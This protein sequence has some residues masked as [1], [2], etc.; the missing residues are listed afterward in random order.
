MDSS[1]KDNGE[2][3]TRSGRKQHVP[4]KY[5]GTVRDQ[6]DMSVL[7]KEQVLRVSKP[8][9]P[10]AETVTSLWPWIILITTAHPEKLPF[11]IHR[12]LRLHTDRNMGGCLD[13]R[14]PLAK[15]RGRQRS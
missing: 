2:I 7:G 8:G 3:Q 15:P 11:R 10:A 13:V 9:I 1:T 6:D 5:L 14:W 4:E 12:C